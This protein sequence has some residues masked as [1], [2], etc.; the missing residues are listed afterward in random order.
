MST[1]VTQNSDTPHPRPND[2]KRGDESV[3]ITA[4]RRQGVVDHLRGELARAQLIAANE[5]QDLR[6]KRGQG[7]PC[8]QAELRASNATAVVQY[9][10]ATLK[11]YGDNRDFPSVVA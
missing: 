3:R 2:W 4:I 11:A 10:G 9:L 6:V 8:A 7:M 5:C 1:Q